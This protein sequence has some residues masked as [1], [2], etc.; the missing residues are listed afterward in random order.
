[1]G[2]GVRRGVVKEMRVGEG[3]LCEECGRA[4]GTKTRAGVVCGVR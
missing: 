4:R 3:V 2:L 1:M